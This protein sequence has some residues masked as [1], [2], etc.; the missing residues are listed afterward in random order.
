MG[1]NQPVLPITNAQRGGLTEW[2]PSGTLPA[3][4]V[5]RARLV[6]TLADGAS[7]SQVRRS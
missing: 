7:Y 5:F 1:R 4:E 6:L 3:G 2:A